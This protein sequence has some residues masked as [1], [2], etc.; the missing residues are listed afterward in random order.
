MA[1]QNRELMLQRLKLKQM[2]MQSVFHDELK[3]VYREQ[4]KFRHDI[5]NHLQVMS[6]ADRK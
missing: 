4:R 3:E 2:E 6:G 5:K 1:Y